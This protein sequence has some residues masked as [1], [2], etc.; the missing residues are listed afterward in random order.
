MKKFVFSITLL[1]AAVFAVAQPVARVTDLS[2]KSLYF[3]HERQVLIYTPEGY[4]EYDATDFDVMY[5]FDSQNMTLQISTSCMCSTRK[6]VRSS[7]SCIV[8]WIWHAPTIRTRANA[9]SSLAS[10][11]PTFLTLITIVIPIICPCP[12][13]RVRKV[14]DSL[15]LN[16][17]MV[18]REI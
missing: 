13:M 7:I 16:K 9:L 15:N 14:K 17:A 4:D 18:V 11:H 2:M 10:V 3:N 6:N 1:F 8:L 12:S 5:V